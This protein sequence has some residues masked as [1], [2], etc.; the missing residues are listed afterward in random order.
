MPEYLGKT[1]LT[2]TFR[3][4]V[5]TGEVSGDLQG[6]F[7]IEAL[8]RQ[9]RKRGWGLELIA[10]GGDRMAHAGATLIC[11][12]TAI[13]SVGILESI[14]YIWPTLQ[15]QR[16]TRQILEQ[17]PPD[18]VVLVD[19]GGPNLRLG[20]YLRKRF[21]QVPIVYYIAPQYWVWEKSPKEPVPMIRMVDQVLAIFPE[22]ARY[23]DALGASV[24]WVG[25]P[26]LD[27]AQTAPQREPARDQLGIPPEQW[28]IALLPAS[29]QQEITFLWPMMAQAAQILQGRFPQIH[30]W[31][32][33]SQNRFRPLLEGTIQ[34][35]GLRATVVDDPTQLVLAAA[36]LAL[37]KSGTVNLEIALL[38][39]PQVVVYRLNPVTAWIARRWLKFAVPFISPVNLVEMEAIVPELLQEAA[40]PER[41]V[42]ESEEL[43]L[44]KSRRQHQLQGYGRMKQALGEP[45]VCDRAAHT[46]LDH[47]DPSLRKASQT[48]L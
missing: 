1:T 29:R 44:N 16:Q 5:S 40:S 34:Q 7:L 20:T 26:L 39:V 46:I 28:A 41:I 11:N 25:H 30:F 36:D 27:W 32:P 3:V 47:L 2:Q 24:T 19:Y 42:Q 8:Q 6:A 15:A 45:G 10:L 48:V 43:L 4:L 14:P 17:Q 31:I 33:L 9:A 35:Y 38:G 18:L 22:E 37:T 13:G 21:P 12:T 23:F